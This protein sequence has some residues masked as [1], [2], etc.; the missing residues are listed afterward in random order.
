MRGAMG[1]NTASVPS[2]APSVLVRWLWRRLGRHFPTMIGIALALVVVVGVEVVQPRI[3]RSV[4]DDQLRDSAGGD[5][6]ALVTLGLYYLATVGAGFL[7]SYVATGGLGRLGAKVMF[8]LRQGLFIHM[9]NL[10]PAFYQKTPVGVLVHRVSNDV[11]AVSDLFTQVLNTAVRDVILIVGITI[12]MW[13][14]DPSLALWILAPLPFIFVAMVPFG[15][16]VFGLFDKIRDLSTRMIIALNE[17]LRGLGL[18]RAF[19]AEGEAHARYSSLNEQSYQAHMKS[20]RAFSLFDPAVSLAYYISLALLFLKGVPAVMEGGA[21]TIGVL[22]AMLAYTERLYHPLHD[23]AQKFHLVQSSL[24][25]VGKVHW[26][27]TVDEPDRWSASVSSKSPWPLTTALRVEGLCY[28]YT[29]RVEVVRGVDFTIPK[30]QKLAI[31][32]STGAGKSTLVKL[33]MS[34]YPPKSGEIWADDSPMTGTDVRVW[35]RGLAFLPQEVTLFHRSVL[36]NIRLHE[37]IPRERVEMVLDALGVTKR[38][39]ALPQ[40]LD[41]VLAEGGRDLSL[42]ERQIIS[43]ARALAFEPEVLIL[44]EATSSI[45]PELELLVTRAM[46]KLLEGRTAILIAHRLSTVRKADEIVVMHEG[47]VVERGGHDDLM[48]L[49]GR[50]Y[51]LVRLQLTA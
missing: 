7:F 39:A 42:G 29:K 41:T 35:R 38:I 25:G 28:G 36:D 2:V 34:Y 1:P 21:T 4:I 3:I 22:V 47:Q 50:Y 20:I 11:Q 24:A 49:K 16:W 46:D 17:I 48:A 37:D 5:P 32:G 9:A 10:R 43:I 6:A 27:M 23:L 40:G 33:L 19:D 18:L 45:D 15:R 14:M 13:S 44:D 51:N 8:D 31:V 26:L 12:A 30:G